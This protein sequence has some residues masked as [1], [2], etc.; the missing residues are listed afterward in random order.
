MY[1]PGQFDVQENILTNLVGKHLSVLLKALAS[2]YHRAQGS[3]VR[4]ILNL[5]PLA[6]FVLSFISLVLV[7]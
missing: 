3:D 6:Y 4:L 2:R 5:W 7:N 1:V